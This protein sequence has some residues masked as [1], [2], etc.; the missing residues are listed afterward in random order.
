M[1]VRAGKAKTIV[2]IAVFGWFA[3]DRAACVA[4]F[5]SPGIRFFF[6]FRPKRKNQFISED[7][8][9]NF[10]FGCILKR[11]ICKKMHNKIII[12]N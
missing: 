11:V 4:D 7:P 5:G 12:A 9:R 6:T 2:A 1:P 3:K 8:V 10:S